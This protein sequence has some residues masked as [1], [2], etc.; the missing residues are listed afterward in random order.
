MREK[1]VVLDRG[2]VEFLY[3]EAWNVTRNKDGYI[4]L[5]DPTESCRLEVSYTK[6]PPE[7][8]GVA[9]DRLL[10]Q[11]LVHVP[12]AGSSPE[13]QTSSESNRRFA[14]A[15]SG[16]PSTNK[17]TGNEA[18]ARGRWL[19]GSNDLFQILMTY[20]Y[21][22]EDAAWAVPAWERIVETLSF[23]DGSQLESPEDH[24]SRRRRN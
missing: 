11:L 10:R 24:W 23:G 22:A 6:V 18:E 17:R 1:I 19:V 3:P 16:Y 9:L 14:W 8:A 12:E 2:N 7:A 15:D 4:T 20:Y 13:I 5:T 21:W